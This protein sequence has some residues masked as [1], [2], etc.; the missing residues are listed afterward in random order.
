MRKKR[1]RLQR[2]TYILKLARGVVIEVSIPEAP[3]ANVETLVLQLGDSGLDDDFVTGVLAEGLSDRISDLVT[4]GKD[5]V[6]SLIFIE[7]EI[8][9]LF[10]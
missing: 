1:E 5:K 10:I 7:D 8:T 9:K 3:G 4:D 6:L 2:N